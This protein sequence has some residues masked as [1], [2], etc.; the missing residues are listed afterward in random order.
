[1]HYVLYAVNTGNSMRTSKHLQN[2]NRKKD[3][4]KSGKNL[5]LITRVLGLVLGLE[6]Q[7][8]VNI[9]D[10]TRLNVTGSPVAYS[11]ICK[12]GV[13]VGYI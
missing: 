11:E 5:T 13:R 1:M 6:A 3:E 2:I 9:T 7:V 8:F 4:R 10:L 12:R